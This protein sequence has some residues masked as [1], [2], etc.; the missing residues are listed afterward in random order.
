MP[1]EFWIVERGELRPYLRLGE[2]S[3]CGDCCRGKRVTARFTCVPVEV[4]SSSDDGDWSGWEGWSANLHGGLWRWWLTSE[5]GEERI[6]PALQSGEC[7]AWRSEGFPALCRDWP[8]HPRDLE[9][10]PRCSFR[11]EQGE[12]ENDKVCDPA[13]PPGWG[14]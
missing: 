6:C 12:R 14:G 9:A 10:F 13:S 8:V 3:M 1:K 5:G 2:C 7:G 4:D 11:F